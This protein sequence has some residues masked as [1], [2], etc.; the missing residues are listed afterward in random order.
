MEPPGRENPTFSFKAIEKNGE[1]ISG[2][3]CVCTSS[4]FKNRTRNIKWLDSKEF[5]SLRNVS[6]IEFNGQEVVI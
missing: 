3:N 5:R 6:F 1:I 4:N 2:E